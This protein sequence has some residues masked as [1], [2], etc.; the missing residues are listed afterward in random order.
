MKMGEGD[1][2][3]NALELQQRLD[4]ESIERLKRFAAT[5]DWLVSWRDAALRDEI[6]RTLADPRS[7]TVL[8]A[9]DTLI[10]RLG[11]WPEIEARG[12]VSARQHWRREVEPVLTRLLTGPEGRV[13]RTLFRE[14]DLGRSGWEQ[15]F[16]ARLAG[17]DPGDV[18]Y[19]VSF[20]AF[21]AHSFSETQEPVPAPAASEEEVGTIR[22]ALLPPLDIVRGPRYDFVAVSKADSALAINNSATGATLNG[23]GGASAM[24]QAYIV[25]GGGA[26]ALSMIGASFTLPKG[27]ERLTCSA[28]LDVNYDAFSIAGLAGSTASANVVLRAELSD[29]TW[30]GLTQMLTAIPSPFF[31]WRSAR[32]NLVDM[33]LDIANI[34]VSSIEGEVRVFAGVEVFSAASGI[35]GSSAA[36]MTAVYTL[37]RLSIAAR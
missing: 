34:D 5:N 13:A 18:R 30:S 9:T 8:E 16:Y 26:Q 28:T 25:M 24:S 2:D 17:R 14:G 21:G 11:A 27:Y 10:K 29:G 35:V 1:L 4:S 36:R 31:V 22:Q 12:G 32:D 19:N 37:K 23:S 3:A 15:E 20:D 33:Q 6:Q 7:K